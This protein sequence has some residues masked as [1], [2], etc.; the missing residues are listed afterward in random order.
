MGR[1]FDFFYRKK[2]K[3]NHRQPLN[4]DMPVMSN[5][6]ADRPSAVPPRRRYE[7][8]NVQTVPAQTVPYNQPIPSGNDRANGYESRPSAVPPRK[9]YEE[10]NIQTVPVQVVPDTVPHNQPIQSN[11]SRQNDSRLSSTLPQMRRR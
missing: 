2:H 8:N 1:I 6:Y 9:R 11:K 3:N 4:D 5:D 10:N 7:Q